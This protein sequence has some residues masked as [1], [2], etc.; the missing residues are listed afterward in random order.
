V[1]A[2]EDRSDDG[3]VRLKRMSR[4]SDLYSTSARRQSVDI[5]QTSVGQAQGD[6]TVFDP[7]N[8]A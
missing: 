7:Q 1:I 3:K 5:L 6:G 2:R 4:A 8:R